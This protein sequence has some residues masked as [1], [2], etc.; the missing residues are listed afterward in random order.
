MSPVLLGWI[1]ICKGH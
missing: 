1:S